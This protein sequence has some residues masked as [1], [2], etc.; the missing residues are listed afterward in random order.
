MNAPDKTKAAAA[1]P[2]PDDAIIVIPMRN[3][4][5]FPGVISPIT[6]PGATPKS[7]R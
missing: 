6:G 2:L 4:V 1:K 5:L 7:S 3:T